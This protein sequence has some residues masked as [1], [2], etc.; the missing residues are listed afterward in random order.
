MCPAL[1]GL[2]HMGS[3]LHSL[4]GLELPEN[5]WPGLGNTSACGSAPWGRVRQQSVT[6][7]SSQAPDLRSVSTC[8]NVSQPETRC[9]TS[10]YRRSE[11]VFGQASREGCCTS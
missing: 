7:K 1:S 10:R 11:G 3:V 6:A 8:L 9:C 2:G 4:R 5:P